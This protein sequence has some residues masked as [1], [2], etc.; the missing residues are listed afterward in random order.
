MLKGCGRIMEKHC[1]FA[2][3]AQVGQSAI[4]T[5][6]RIYHSAGLIPAS[7]EGSETFPDPYGS[8][9]TELVY[10]LFMDV[11]RVALLPGQDNRI[12]LDIRLVGT[13]RVT[14]TGQPAI[15]RKILIDTHVLV[16]LKIDIIDFTLHVGLDPTDAEVKSIDLRSVDPSGLP[17]SFADFLKS[18]AATQVLTVLLRGALAQIKNLTPP[19]MQPLLQQIGLGSLVHVSRT[20]VRVLDS[21]VAV[22]LDLSPGSVVFYT[23]GEEA[24]IKRFLVTQQSTADM[25]IA[26]NPSLQVLFNA[27]AWGKANE[28]IAAFNAKED[29]CIVIDHLS[30][31]VQEGGFYVEGHAT[32]EP[33]GVSFNLAADVFVDMGEDHTYTY[34]DE[35]GGTY[36]EV[37]PGYPSVSMRMRDVHVSEEIPWWAW[38]GV[39]AG[40]LMLIGPGGPAIVLLAAAAILDAIRSRIASEIDQGTLFDQGLVQR[41]SLPGTDAPLIKCALI[42]VSVN[43]R[44]LHT[45]TTITP[46][47][48]MAGEIDG[49]KV[50]QPEDWG[51]P[52]EAQSPMHYRLRP[53]PNLFHPRDP[54]VR[55]RWQA[56][57]MDTNEIIASQ[58]L[59]LLAPGSSEFLVQPTPAVI[60]ASSKF[61][62][63]CRV[64]R[65][66]GGTV[67]EIINR[68]ITVEI[69]GSARPHPSLCNVEAQ[70]A[71]TSDRRVAGGP[72]GVAELCTY[73]PRFAHSQ[74][75]PYRALSLC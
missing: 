65:P 39:I 55:I 45:R 69:S 61:K 62:I 1:N 19:L 74:N 33:F 23:W 48:A 34:E 71:C 59:L 14:R 42:H 13:A 64:Y 17:Q 72:E 66:I 6:L 12:G 52:P 41:M 70:Y 5:V 63:S 43:P 31:T 22:A 37:Y 32:R 60:A 56:H 44:A 68:T 49:P 15:E 25:A 67:E 73:H 18:P 53:A 26:A 8:G 9:N 40:S 2:A 16:R 38:F 10:T 51:K 75:G 57:R 50:L 7:V 35:Y 46:D 4:Q 54:L 29:E 20:V 27:V 21:A 58:D 11:P 30:T 47:W 24:E 3:I 36:T 28:A